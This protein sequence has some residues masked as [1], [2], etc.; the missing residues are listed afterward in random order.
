MMANWRQNSLS[1]HVAPPGGAQ[2]DAAE[3]LTACAK[4]GLSHPGGASSERATNVPCCAST[5][6]PSHDELA[7]HALHDV[8]VVDVPPAV[9]EPTAHVLQRLAFPALYL[10]SAPHAEHVLLPPAAKRP[11]PHGVCTLLPSHHEP[12]VHALHELRVVDVPPAVNEPAVHVK[13]LPLPGM[14]GWYLLSL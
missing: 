6:L 7:A 12:A 14:S 11:V 1:L 3:L 2:H 8:R 4:L 5:L 10:V 13:Q 9:N